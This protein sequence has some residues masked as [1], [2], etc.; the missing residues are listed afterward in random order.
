MS[1]GLKWAVNRSQKQD[2]RWRVDRQ[3]L[4][5]SPM[6]NS[7]YDSVSNMPRRSRPWRNGNHMQ[8]L[9]IHL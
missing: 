8:Q 4:T 5:D 6:L 3:I 1:K 2:S 7:T 9:Q